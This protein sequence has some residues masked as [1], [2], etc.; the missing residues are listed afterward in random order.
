VGCIERSANAPLHVF[1][2]YPSGMASNPADSA[3]ASG[4]ESKRVVPRRWGQILMLTFFLGQVGN[5]TCVRE[6]A[7]R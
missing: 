3:L 6:L 4:S 2:V 1:G 5:P 7:L